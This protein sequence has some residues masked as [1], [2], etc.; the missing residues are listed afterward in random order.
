M[1]MCELFFKVETADKIQAAI[2]E[3]TGGPCP[4]FT[5]QPCP[6]MPASLELTTRDGRTTVGVVQRTPH[7]PHAAA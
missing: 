4:C 3:M 6:V 2:E 5:D 7:E 1:R